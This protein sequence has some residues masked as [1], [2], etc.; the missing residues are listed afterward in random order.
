MKEHS[1][2]NL[3]HLASLLFCNAKF[4]V[5]CLYFGLGQ[6]RGTVVTSAFITGVLKPKPGL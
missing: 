1:R 4:E 6:R 5:F 3:E 2:R